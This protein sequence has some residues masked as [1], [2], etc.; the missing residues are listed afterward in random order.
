M[1]KPHPAVTF[2]FIESY[3]D[4]TPIFTRISDRITRGNVYVIRNKLLLN[5]FF[6]LPMTQNKMM[7][8]Q[9]L[10]LKVEVVTERNLKVCIV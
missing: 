2:S 9:R 5:V 8:L 3:G 10:N 6:Y 7:V 4:Q 1:F